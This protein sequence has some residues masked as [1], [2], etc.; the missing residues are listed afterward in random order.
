M[1][2]VTKFMGDLVGNRV[3]SWRNRPKFVAYP[4]N[5]IDARYYLGDASF[6][7]EA[8]KAL[9]YSISVAKV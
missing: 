5:V 7:K 9:V 3:E 2:R 1:E 6:F 4:W 8:I